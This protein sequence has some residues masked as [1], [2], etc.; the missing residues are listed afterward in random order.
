M[1]KFQRRVKVCNLFKP[2]LNIDCNK[3]LTKTS[4][5]KYSN[6]INF[7]YIV[8]LYKSRFNHERLGW[9]HFKHP[10]Y[11]RYYIGVPE[12][13]PIGAPKRYEAGAMNAFMISLMIC[14]GNGNWIKWS[15]VKSGMTVKI[16]AFNI[17]TIPKYRTSYLYATEEG[18]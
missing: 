5:M 15:D 12:M 3:F 8:L 11:D 1:I 9:L 7:P 10:G 6:L 4:N 18:K 14:D 13:V 2:V 17:D 16:K